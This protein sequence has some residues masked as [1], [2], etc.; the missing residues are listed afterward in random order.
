MTGLPGRMVC[1]Y[2]GLG[3][4]MEGEFGREDIQYAC[5]CVEFEIIAARPR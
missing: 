4:Q 2:I 1:P 3:A 5:K